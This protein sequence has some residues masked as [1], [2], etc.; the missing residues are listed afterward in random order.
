MSDTFHIP[1]LLN[2]VIEYLDPQDGEIAF[3]A[4]LGGGGHALEIAKR[5]SPNG[6]LIATDLDPESI[7]VAEKKFLEAEIKSKYFLRK[8]NYRKIDSVLTEL[9]LEQ[10]DIVLADL[11]L[12]SYDFESSGRGFSFQKDEP[13]DMRFDPESSPEYKRHEPRTAKFLLKSLTEKELETMF[14]TYGEEKFSKKIARAI[15]EQRQEKE[16][17]TTAD[18]FELIK[19]ALPA[20]FRFKAGD[21]ARRIFQSLR[22]EVNRELENIEEFLPKAFA[23]LKPG[24]RMAVIS[25]HSLEDRI[26]KHFFLSKAKGCICPPDFPQCVCGKTPEGKILT[27]KP[28][29]PSEEEVES[30]RRSASAK[31]RVLQK[32]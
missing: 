18:L 1:V 27:R 30:N 15:V 16:I 14:S 23:A 11:G 6:I 22:I 8:A 4:T 2:E 28:V 32:V 29:G 3:D 10:V 5:I 17:E 31:M 25:F 19:K 20:K 24:G 7:K 12:S 13:L 9:G 26:V 21:S